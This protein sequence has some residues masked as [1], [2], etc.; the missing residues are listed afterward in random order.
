MAWF[1]M[2]GADSVEYHRQTV[3]ARGDDHAGGTLAY[4]GSRG[5]TPLVWGGS[6]A[7]RLGLAGAVGDPAYEAVF[8]PGGA[9]DPVL[10]TRLTTTTRPGVELVVSAHKTVA[11]LGLLG[12][13]D[14]MHA[15]LDAETDATL[16]FLDAWF[17]R[18]G[19][20]RGRDQRRT[21]TAGLLWARTR[22]AT[23]RAGDPAP[24]DHVLIA[25]VTEM[26]DAAG[27]WKALDSGALRDLVHAATMVGRLAAAECAVQLGYALGA[28]HGPSGRLDHWAIAGIPAE[29]TDLFSKRSSAIDAAMEAEEFT[30]YRAR[31]I[32]ALATRD[33]KQAETHDELIA[34]WHG[35]L[36]AIGWPAG[37]IEQRLQIVQ[38]RRHRPLRSLSEQERA[39]IVQ[40]LLGPSGPLC[41]R[42]AF[43]RA[44][45]IRLAAPCLYGCAAAELDR[46]VTAVV[47]HP[48][49]IP[50][51]GQPGSRSRAW[52]AASALATEAA[53]AEVA[54]RMAERTH[55]PAVR[56]SAIDRALAAR[57]ARLR[58][59][60][61][62]GQTAAAR[63]VATSG[64]G[65]DLIV[66]VAGSG[67]TTVLEAVRSAF[68]R[69]G[70]TVLGT[71][72][73]GQAARTLAEAAGVE[74]NTVASLRWRLSHGHVRLDDRTVVVLDE[75]AMT[76]DTDLLVVL[77]AADAAGAKVV[78][79]G[80]HRQLGAVGP[81]GGLEAL[82]DRHHPGVHALTDNIRQRDPAERSALEELRSGHIH[83]AVAWYADHGRLRIAP[84]RELALDAAVDGWFAD[85]RAGAETLLL[86]WRRANVAALNERARARW[87]AAG[88]LHGPELDVAGRRYAA[89]DRIV[90]LAPDHQTGVVTSER[91]TVTEVDDHG[92]TARMDNGRR[93]HLGRD[94][95][96]HDRLD[97]AYAMTVH[98]TQGATAD[99]SHVFGDGGGRELA[100]VAMSRARGPSYSY[101]V[102]DDLAQAAEDLRREWTSERRQRWVLDTDSPAPAGIRRQ[103]HLAPQAERSL[104]AARL[105][106]ERAALLTVHGPAA[107]DRLGDA[108]R[109]A[110]S[111]RAEFEDLRAGDGRY[112]H[113][114]IGSASRRFREAEWNHREARRLANAPSSTRRGRRRHQRLAETWAAEL[115][116][117][118]REW[119]SVA[120]PTE[121]RLVMALARAERI[122][123]RLEVDRA[124]G[125]LDRAA[126]VGIHARLS[127]IDRELAQSDP[128]QPAHVGRAALSDKDL[129]GLTL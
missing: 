37:K 68:E 123:S 51:V 124:R 32:A 23:S 74:S 36:E 5:E 79:A 110:A 116:D 101:T 93:V 41:E 12:R 18:Q 73:S 20:R 105:R 76:D 31:G 71:A 69:S 111:I 65:L 24:H 57:Q 63:A 89:G 100:Y 118:R 35:E 126:G 86:A 82:V 9:Q 11:V 81:G 55:A 125:A 56:L 46:V 10:Q 97:H 117:A 4:Y 45:V 99:A 43:T 49:A 3:A 66:G 38:Q 7:D 78:A 8:G 98:R 92:L 27:G 19:G 85:Q 53:V 60:L 107:I 90:A 106:A 50:L 29:V 39:E 13:A 34:R 22:H 95:L 70:H 84:T 25:N 75:A 61:T 33:G 108:R 26:R 127:A 21:A 115:A 62:P 91:G 2:M 113:T 128:R 119:T 44:D 120:A 47:R 80:D 122:V 67:K 16:A 30:S 40:A 83:E 104:R 1:R 88:R 109:R 129:P 112:S 64:R 77:G 59:R 17:R 121:R 94:A 58:G 28:D 102:A 87:A 103:P 6:L 48:E 96:G 54:Q 52:A 15:I 114:A 14:D 42:K 72:T